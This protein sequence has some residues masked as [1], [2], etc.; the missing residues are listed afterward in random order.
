MGQLA[1]VLG[2]WLVTVSSF[3]GCGGGGDT[4]ETST[5]RESRISDRSDRGGRASRT[6]PA[7]SQR[8]PE[9][10]R[11]IIGAAGGAKKTGADPKDSGDTA[12]AA[13]SAAPLESPGLRWQ[14]GNGPVLTSTCHVTLVVNPGLPSVLQLSSY[15]DPD[16]EIFPSMLQRAQTKAESLAQLA[17][18]TLPVSLFAQAERDGASFH[19]LPDQ[20]VELRIQRVDGDRV[21]GSFV[22]MVHDVASRRDSRIN[23]QFH[24]VAKPS[25]SPPAVK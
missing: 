8:E 9:T 4:A 16:R 10:A 14:I 15:P 12:P 19:N 6:K 21:Y 2:A 7:D 13:E 23:G 3:V 5:E 17:G 11:V 18:Q 24:A 1:G 22:G 25:P 20:T